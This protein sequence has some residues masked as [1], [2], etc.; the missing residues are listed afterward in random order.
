M[1]VLEAYMAGEHGDVPAAASNVKKASP[2][3]APATQ[4]SIEPLIDQTQK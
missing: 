4:S 3:M 1:H 2:E